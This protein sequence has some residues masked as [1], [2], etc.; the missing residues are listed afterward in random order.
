MGR[1]VRRIL[2]LSASAWEYHDPF[3]PSFP[4]E[5][6]RVGIALNCRSVAQSS[7]SVVSKSHPYGVESFNGGA[8]LEE[9]KQQWSTSAAAFQYFLPTR[10]LTSA[11][12]LVLVRLG[13][14]DV[15]DESE[16]ISGLEVWFHRKGRREGGQ[17]GERGRGRRCYGG[18]F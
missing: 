3:P 13:L 7:H 4:A 5:Q 18:K 12:P 6:Q 11:H 10:T 2:H 17:E 1:R 8:T 14:A 9:R 16:N 15:D